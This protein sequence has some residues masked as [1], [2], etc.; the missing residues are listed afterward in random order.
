MTD[1]PVNFIL[2]KGGRWRL[3]ITTILETLQVHDDLSRYACAARPAGV[4]I[5]HGKRG[6]VAKGPFAT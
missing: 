3:K 6:R 2:E 4:S 5:A 1:V